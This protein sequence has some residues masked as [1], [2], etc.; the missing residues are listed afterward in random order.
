[1]EP[2]H[3]NWTS[4]DTA[5][6]SNAFHRIYPD[7]ARILIP[8]Y[9]S[10]R[11]CLQAEGVVAMEAMRDFPRPGLRLLKDMEVGQAEVYGLEMKIRAGHLAIVACGASGCVEYQELLAVI[12]HH[13]T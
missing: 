11:A 7:D 9:G 2:H 10:G 13:G 1:M 12:L 8:V 3:S 6:A 5:L 4:R